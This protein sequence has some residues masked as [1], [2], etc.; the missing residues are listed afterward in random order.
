VKPIEALSQYVRRRRTDLN[1]TQQQLA[2]RAGVTR[3]LV[4]HLEAGRL[5]VAPQIPNL[6]RLAVG[7]DVE[8]QTLLDILDTGQIPG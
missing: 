6:K 4:G 7:L 1:L 8:F 2:D 3:A 5:R